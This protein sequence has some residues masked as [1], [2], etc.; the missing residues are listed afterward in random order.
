MAKGTILVVGSGG[1]EHALAWSLARSP[2]AGQV[3]VAP[4]NAGTAVPPKV[5]NVPLRADDLAGLRDFALARQVD[6]TVVGPEAPLAAGIVDAFQSAGLRCFGPTQAAA[7]I[8]SSKAFAKS[9]M[10]EAGVPTAHHVTFTDFA[11][12]RDYVH[13]QGGRV[14]VKASGLAAGKGVTVCSSVGEAEEALHAALVQ[15]AFG[16]AGETVVIEERLAGPELS[17]LGFSDGRTLIPLLTARDHKA[18]YDGDQGPNTGGMGAVSPVPGVGDVERLADLALRPI[19]AA[20]AQRGTPYIGV[21]YAGLMLTRDGPRVLE[22]NCRLGDPEA[23]AILPLL[24]TDLLGL[25]DDCLAGTLDRVRLGWREDAAATVVLASGGYPGAYR[26]GFPI[27]GLEAAGA[28][29]DVL[30]FHAGTKR[31]GDGVVTA[32]GRV[33]NVTA[34]G[35]T[36]PNALAR[37][38]EG[39]GCIS[40][41]GMHYRRDIG[42][43]VAHSTVSD[44][45]A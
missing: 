1:R 29:S 27:R 13:R 26:T 7:Q 11:A 9:L 41:E 31:Q 43:S 42:H 15:R 33:L 5:E 40:F 10:V 39:V 36:L 17:L 18:A 4:G 3:F 6:I 24:E 32:G 22:Y 12:A 44:F 14:V 20:L 2:E 38:Y 23:Q 19:I 25:L 34:C 35:A 8:E 28:L 21:L 45:T 16:E 37:A 30:V